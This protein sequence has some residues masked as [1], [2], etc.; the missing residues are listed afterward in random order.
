MGIDK[1][2]RNIGGHSYILGRSKSDLDFQSLV[3]DLTNLSPDRF[4]HLQTNS[5]FSKFALLKVW[6]SDIRFKVTN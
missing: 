2:A 4:F 6:R 3:T 1:N 5:N